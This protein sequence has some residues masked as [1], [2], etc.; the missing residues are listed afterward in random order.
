MTLSNPNL[1]DSYTIADKLHFP[2]RVATALLMTLAVA[3]VL[4][5]VSAWGGALPADLDLLSSLY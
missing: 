4:I 5:E 2:L 1:S 3:L